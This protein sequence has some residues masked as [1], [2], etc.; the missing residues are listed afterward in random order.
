MRCVLVFLF[1]VFNMGSFGYGEENLYKIVI[2][3]GH[4]GQDLGAT[5]NSFVESK[6]VLDIAKKIKTQLEKEK[7]L[8]VLLTRNSNTT[9]SL[10]N[11]VQMAQEFKADLF[12]SLHANTSSIKSIQGMEFYF[13]SASPNKFA[14]IQNKI[15]TNTGAAE[16]AGA[17]IIEKIKSDFKFYDKT[18]KS[19]LLSRLL[20]NKSV[21]FEQKNIIK[22][23]PFYVLDHSPMPS[24]LIELGFITNRQEA[25]KLATSKYQN[26][27]ARLLSLAIL[28][29]KEKSDKLHLL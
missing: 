11:R 6:I 27:I 25:R 21:E 9:L 8:S 4:G 15:K 17:Q 19:L 3:P 26:E 20:K 18:E 22:R 12:I 10:E 23:A 2:D 16:L 5:R 13:N 24:V 1:F 28:E 29:Y 7:N 14:E